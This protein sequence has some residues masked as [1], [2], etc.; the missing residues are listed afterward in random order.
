MGDRERIECREDGLVYSWEWDYNWE[1]DHS[2][3]SKVP[4]D[5]DDPDALYRLRRNRA[6]RAV[7]ESWERSNGN[8]NQGSS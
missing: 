7:D 3:D 2:Q 1:W 4:K 8:G 5:I 6:E